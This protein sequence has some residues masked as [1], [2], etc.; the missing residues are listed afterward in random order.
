MNVIT[1]ED[2]GGEAGKAF[3][4]DLQVASYGPYGNKPEGDPITYDVPIQGNLVRYTPS[5]WAL[6]SRMTKEAK[7][8]GK[9]GVFDKMAKELGFAANYSLEVQGHRPLNSG[10]GTTGG[11]G[12]TAA[13]FDTLALFSTAHTLLRGGTAAN[14]LTTDVDLS[15]TGLEL[16]Y[17]TLHGTVNES[18]MP[19]PMIPQL[20]VYHYTQEWIVKELLNSNQ[21]P[22]TNTNDV[23]TV[24]SSV[25]PIT[26]HYL[27]DTDSYFVL[28]AKGRHDLNMW[29][30][31]APDFETGDDFDTGDSK[32]KGTFRVAVGHGDWRGS[33]GSAGA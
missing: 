18:N 19:T 7:Q 10:F 12:F 3:F 8:D 24:K 17:D 28:A 23:N 27:T 11:T 4:D 22:W 2:P 13:G 14:R 25:T 5:T 21:K 31:Q 6:G 9:Y 20:L 15:Q 33:F 1:G 30:R 29:M 26:S 16:A 32:M